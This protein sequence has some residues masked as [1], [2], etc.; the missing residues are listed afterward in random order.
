MLFSEECI[1]YIIPI[2]A[3]GVSQLPLYILISHMLLRL[4]L[5]FIYLF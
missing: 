2:L 5:S 1:D 4:T 3:A